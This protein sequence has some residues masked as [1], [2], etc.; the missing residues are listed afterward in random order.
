MESTMIHLQQGGDPGVRRGSLACRIRVQG[1]LGDEWSE[2]TGGLNVVVQRRGTG[3]C[4]TELVGTL[5]D[6]AALMGVLDRLYSHGARLL[7]VDCQDATSSITSTW[8][9]TK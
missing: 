9:S 7:G 2:R 8:T 6:R 3:A 1:V 5:P 4:T